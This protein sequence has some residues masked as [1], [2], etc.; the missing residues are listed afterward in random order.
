MLNAKLLLKII[1]AIKLYDEI[2]K[3]M[4]LNKFSVALVIFLLKLQKNYPL[5]KTTSRYF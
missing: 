1:L 4:L 2:G 5:N 3:E